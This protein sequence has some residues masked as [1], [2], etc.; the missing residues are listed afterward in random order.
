MLDDGLLPNAYDTQ[1]IIALEG[2]RNF[3]DL[4]GYATTDGRRIK[5]GLVF[6]SGSLAGLTLADWQSLQQRGVRSM[7]DLRTTHERSSEPFAWKDAA[8][9]TY[10]ARD[11][12]S[13]FGELRRVMASDLPS[14]AA[15][16]A[17]MI[18]GYKE[19]PFEQATAYRQI[20]VHLAANTVPL[21]FNCSAG[22]DRAG[23]AAALIL[24]ALGVSRQTLIEDYLLTNAAVDLHQVLAGGD[25]KRSMLAKRPSDVTAAIL[26]ADAAYITSALEAIDERHGSIEAYLHEVL[27]I[28]AAQLAAIKHNLL[29]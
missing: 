23:T 25:N 27:G 20:F 2:G 11:Y 16:R 10:F 12:A 26:N 28:N 13:S 29:E 6:R 19:L 21:I 14:G 22:K 15:A 8:T 3:R 7:C 9:L 17:A 5:W 1:R 4:G 24:S 18:A